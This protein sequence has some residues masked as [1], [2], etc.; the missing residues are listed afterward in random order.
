MLTSK[1]NT[2]GAMDNVPQNGGK[3]KAFSAIITDFEN[4]MT[5]GGDYSAE[6]TDLAT[7]VAFSVIRKCID[8]Q[9][10]TAGQ[11]DHTDNS[12][13]NPALLNVRRDI[14]ADRALLEKP[15]V[16]PLSQGKRPI[17]QTATP[18]RPPRQRRRQRPFNRYRA[19]NRRRSRPCTNGGTCHS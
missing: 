2:S 1:L 11:L 10:K 5:K 19:D 7:A 9:R 15:A 4:A 13:L 12:G 3:V 17:T 18:F 14:A 6:L 16:F 8:P